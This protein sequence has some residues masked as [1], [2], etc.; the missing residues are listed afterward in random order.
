MQKQNPFGNFISVQI[1]LDFTK[2]KKKKKNNPSIFPDMHLTL[3][4]Y[5]STL[6][7][8]IDNF[9]HTDTVQIYLSVSLWTQGM[10][11]L[12]LIL[13]NP[14]LLFLPYTLYTDILL[15]VMH[16]GQFWPIHKISSLYFFL[17]CHH[18]H[19]ICICYVYIQRYKS[20]VKSNEGIISQGL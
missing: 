3:Y 8:P 17:H 19:Y 5:L 20:R 15:A 11:R 10:S 13:V 18:I 1:S 9:T 14:R 7:I 2:K 16:T 12:V 6:R 4:P